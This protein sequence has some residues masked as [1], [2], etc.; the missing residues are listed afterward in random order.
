MKNRANLKALEEKKRS[1][2]SFCEWNSLSS[3]VHPVAN[4]VPIDY[5]AT[6]TVL[7][8]EYKIKFIP[9]VVKING[10]V[11]VKFQAVRTFECLQMSGGQLQ[12]LAILSLDNLFNKIR[13]DKYNL[14]RRPG[15]MTLSLS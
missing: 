7:Q 10:G 4:H 2:S 6:L 5:T 13:D 12:V 11:A 3:V 1:S 15:H 8:L 9:N 14:S